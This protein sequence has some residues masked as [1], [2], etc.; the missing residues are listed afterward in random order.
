[1]STYVIEDNK[2]KIQNLF[3]LNKLVTTKI[4]MTQ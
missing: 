1:M 4:L 2:K 3:Q